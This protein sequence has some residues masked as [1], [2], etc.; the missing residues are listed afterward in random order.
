M[1]STW[2]AAPAV[3]NRMFYNVRKGETTYASAGTAGNDC[4]I[5]HATRVGPGASNDK[6]LFLED[7]YHSALKTSTLYPTST[8]YWM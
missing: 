6:T 4:I 3:L 1:L 2:D 7:E 8:I 5:L